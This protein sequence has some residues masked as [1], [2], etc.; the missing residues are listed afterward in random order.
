M[1][2]VKLDDMECDSAELNSLAAP[3]LQTEDNSEEEEEEEGG[4]VEFHDHAY[5][6]T[7]LVA[8]GSDL[9]AIQ[10]IVLVSSDGGLLTPSEATLASNS[11]LGDE[12]MHRVVLVPSSSLVEGA[13]E[14]VATD[15]NSVVQIKMEPPA[16]TETTKKAARTTQK[17]RKPGP[18]DNVWQQPASNVSQSW[19]T[20]K[21]DKMA[22]QVK[23]HQW[24]QGQW[25]HEEVDLLKTNIAHYCQKRHIEDPASVIFNMSKDERKDFYRTVA[26]GLERPLFSVYRRVVRMYDRKNHLGKY[27]PEEIKAL[28]EL[29]LK[30]GSD[31]A[32]IGTFLGRSASSVKDR[33]RLMKDCNA[34]KWLPEEEVRLTQAVY[35]LSGAPPGDEVTQGLSWALVAE[36]V[37]TRSEKQCRTKWLNYLNWKQKGGVEWTRQ[38]D[39]T[40][41]RKLS[42]LAVTDDTQVDWA[43]MAHELQS[44]RSPQWLRGKWWTIK[45]H[46]DGYQ[47]MSLPG[48]QGGLC[49]HIHSLCDA[50]KSWMR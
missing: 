21:D 2:C 32:T 39:L 46:V 31:W 25:S 34:G 11:Q 8:E 40:L 19:F 9:M 14:T 38:D 27:T 33:C 7:G 30:H 22:L 48:E 36:R 16:F 47:L 20:T 49:A 43:V 15:D 13:S 6:D 26:R 18:K 45:R 10:P 1:S 41:I 5:I 24:K 35:D 37:A 4:R 17:Q 28:K 3:S 50:Q 23:G 12:C 42:E 29:R 44:A